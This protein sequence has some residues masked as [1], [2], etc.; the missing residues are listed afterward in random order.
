[1]KQFLDASGLNLYTQALKNG[2]LKVGRAQDSSFANDASTSFYASHASATGLIGIIPMANI[3]HG[4]IDKLVTVADQA[5]MLALD[6]ED[7][8]VGDSVKRLDTGTLYLVVNEEALGTMAAF[9]EY[10]AGRATSA[11]IADWAIDASHANDAD[12]AVEAQHAS[13]ADDASRADSVEWT[14]VQNKPTEFT[15]APHTHKAADV[16]SLVGYT[17]AGTAADVTANDSLLVALGKIEKK[18]DDASDAAK[19]HVQDASTINMTGYHVADE[20]SAVGAS[21]TALTAIEKVEKK[22]LDA[23]NTA[24]YT[25]IINVPSEFTPANHDAAKVVSING[26][27]T[28]GVSGDVEDTDNLA[29]ALAK[30]EVKANSGADQP[31]PDATINKIIAGNF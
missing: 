24:D 12:N 15:P 29:T 22:A 1:M 6:S 19:D 7:V 14:N 13:R 4:A 30:I 18:A 5:A 26:Y 11:A 31:I 2:T 20:Y 21:D 28:S 17:K 16:S 25:Q 3:P 27:S 9:V 8:Q 10:S 23:S